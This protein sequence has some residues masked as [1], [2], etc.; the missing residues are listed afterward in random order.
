MIIIRIFN[1]FVVIIIYFNALK[2]IDLKLL[3]IFEE[4]FW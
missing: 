1:G 4:R 2:I 3:Y